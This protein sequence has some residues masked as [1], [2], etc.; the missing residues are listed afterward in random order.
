MKYLLCTS[1]GLK[2]TI[3]RILSHLSYSEFKLYT[4]I[5]GAA[6]LYEDENILSLCY[7]FVQTRGNWPTNFYVKLRMLP[8]LLRTKGIQLNAFDLSQLSPKML[9]RTELIHFTNFDAIVERSFHAR[10]GHEI[11]NLQDLFSEAE[12]FYAMCWTQDRWLHQVPQITE[13]LAHSIIW[14][15]YVPVEQT[16]PPVKCKW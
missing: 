5:Y 8:Q 4:S 10:T 11:R 15:D 6:S 13:E 7:Y 1:Y 9:H 2:N 14:T 3:W 16:T 12:K